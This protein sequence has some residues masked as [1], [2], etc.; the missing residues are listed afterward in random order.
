MNLSKFAVGRPVTVLIVF[1][2]IFIIGAF[3]FPRLAIDLY[4]KFNPPVLLVMTVYEG[5]GPEYI[6]NNVTRILE[7]ALSNVSDL[8]E[9]NSTS[10]EHRSVITLEFDWSKDM[11]EAANDVRDRLESTKRRLPDGVEP[12]IVF[13][14]DP[15]MAPILR[16]AVEGSRTS[17]ELKKIT[18]DIIQPKIEQIPGVAM[19]DIR[20]G[21][22]NIIRVEVSKNRL[23]AYKL[24][25]VDISNALA[26]QNIDVGAG[27]VESGSYEFLVRSRGEFKTVDEIADAVITRRTPYPG[28]TPVPIKVRDV[29][30]AFEGFEDVTQTVFINERP[31]IYLIVRKQSEANSVQTAAQV[32]IELIRLNK[33]LPMGVTVK[34]LVDATK[35]IKDSINQVSSSAIMGGILAMGILFIFLR[36]VK[37][38]L[39]IGISIPMSLLITMTC[40]YFAGLSLN[41]LS[42]A[43]LTLGVGLVTDSS[44]VILENT[45]RYREKGA[46]LKTSAILGSK[47]MGN[48]ITASAL[49]TVCVFL[50]VILFKADLGIMG[51]M[52]NDLAFTVSVALLAALFVAL[53]FVPVL[54]S[55]Y[56]KIYTKKQRPTKNPFL[57]IIDNKSENFFIGMEK[58]YRRIL[59][60]VLGRRKTTIAAVVFIFVISMVL[61]PLVGLEF[62]PAA[63]EDEVV[64]AVELPTGSTLE[65][66]QEVMDRF[67]RIV[68]DEVKGYENLIKTSGSSSGAFLGR[69]SHRGELSISLPPYKQRIDTADSIKRKLRAHFTE[70]PGL[71]FNFRTGQQRGP[72]NTNPIDIRLKS[73]NLNLSMAMAFE[74]KK[75]LETNIAE[76]TE[77]LT[78]ID[79]SLPEVNV[80]YNRERLYDFGLRAGEVGREIRAAINGEIASIY[81]A[82]GE[83]EIDLVVV[84]RDEDRKSIP[85]LGT[86]Y[87]TNS[88]GEYIPVSSFA[89][90]ETGYG[91]VSIKRVDQTRVVRV[92]AGLE[93]GAKLNEVQKKIEETIQK[94]IVPNDAVR[95]EYKGDY[96]E[97]MKS[98]AALISIVIIALMLVYGVMASQFESFKDPFIMFLVI[99]LMSIGVVGIHLLLAK[100][101][102]LFS[103]IGIVMLLGIVVSNG[104][105]LVD[106]TNLLVKRGFPLGKAC[107]EAGVNRLRPIL[108]TTLSTILGLVPMAFFPGEGS[109]LIQPI[110]QT[111]IGG[112]TTSTAITLV[113]IPVMYYVFNKKKMAEAGKL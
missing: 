38:T 1:S 23:E 108:M 101:F 3:I 90:I 95:I 78:D 50:P 81:R 9:I 24:T 5:A 37:S 85:D 45:Y 68:I 22:T 48:A 80:F 26:A 91:P 47:E 18:E 111:V 106:Y 87:V 46:H 109:E 64:L 97:L 102:S 14:F 89:S 88:R 77:P 73:D 13:K 74:I 57:L 104:I 61:L 54:S 96:G 55:T 49:T 103:I 8:K 63:S 11:T 67:E 34:V 4:P 42:L 2:L 86:I 82:E 65:T 17:H 112:L 92:Q 70:F 60:V 59:N 93:K 113:F 84:L 35:L 20:G 51:V 28:G 27:S 76:L 52:F 66:T 105:V 110:G 36:S 19:T 39:I 75:L 7:A 30:N 83:D 69:S 33:E 107:V 79:N 62:T 12:P 31:G 72:G 94:N 6:E 16:L 71:S 58:L 10:V 53:I 56:L 21:K 40:M 99:P 100:P 32:F 44:I 98:R 25:M 41:I 15:S 29:A 43:G